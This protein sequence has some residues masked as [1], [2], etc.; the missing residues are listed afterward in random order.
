[1][2]DFGLSIRMPFEWFAEGKKNCH[3]KVRETERLLSEV[4]RPVTINIYLF[5]IL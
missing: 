5:I 1:M 4:S 3:K 2:E